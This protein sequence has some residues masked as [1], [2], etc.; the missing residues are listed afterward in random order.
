M[1]TRGTLSPEEFDKIETSLPQF[2][3]PK[4]R[5]RTPVKEQVEAEGEPSVEPVVQSSTEKPVVEQQPDVPQVAQQAP[6]EEEEKEQP[7]PFAEVEG[8]PSPGDTGAE[9][10][11]E[12]EDSMLFGNSMI[13]ESHIREFFDAPET[14][15][16]TFTED[17]QDNRRLWR[18]GGLGGEVAAVLS[19]IHDRWIEGTDVGRQLQDKTELALYPLAD[20]YVG[21]ASAVMRM[22][23][24]V[25]DMIPSLNAKEM[26]NGL[27]EMSQAW[28]A[29]RAQD[30]QNLF[31]EGK[32]AEAF[33]RSISGALGDV[34]GNMKLFLSVGKVVRGGS[35]GVVTKDATWK[36]VAS[37]QFGRATFGFWYAFTNTK[38]TLEERAKAGALSFAYMSTPVVSSLART[39][40]GA[41]AADFLLNSGIDSVWSPESGFDFPIKWVDGKPQ[42]QGQFEDARK[43]AAEEAA[44]LGQPELEEQLFYSKIIPIVGASFG[45]ALL[46]T[47]ARA[48]N[49]EIQRAMADGRPD[50]SK[51]SP[52]VQRYYSDLDASM[53]SMGM[54]DALI[55][56]LNSSAMNAVLDGKISADAMIATHNAS[57]R[58]F[59][60]M[61]DAHTERMRPDGMIEGGRIMPEA[62]QREVSLEREVSEAATRVPDADTVSRV[63]GVMQNKDEATMALSIF[64]QNPASWPKLQSL[65]WEKVREGEILRDPIGPTVEAARDLGAQPAPP[66]GRQPPVIP[67]LTRATAAQAEAERR[68]VQ[69]LRQQ[70]KSLSGSVDK[71]WEA[72]EK[73]PQG[74]KI[75]QLR[76]EYEV[77]ESEG[78]TPRQL[79]VAR[80]KWT[81]AQ[82]RGVQSKEYQTWIDASKRWRDAEQSAKQAEVNQPEKPRYKAPTKEQ[83]VSDLAET[84]KPNPE[85]WTPERIATIETVLPETARIQVIQDFASERPSMGKLS[86][87]LDYVQTMVQ[88]TKSLGYGKIKQDGSMKQTKGNKMARGVSIGL[89]RLK[90]DPEFNGFNLEARLDS[91]VRDTKEFG[92]SSRE[93]IIAS[94][95][96]DSPEE[97]VKLLNVMRLGRGSQPLMDTAL[98][99]AGGAIRAPEYRLPEEERNRIA[100]ALPDGLNPTVVQRFL[101][102]VSEPPPRNPDTFQSWVRA[103]SAFLKQAHS[104]ERMRDPRDLDRTASRWS[105]RA[106]NIQS[107]RYFFENI[108]SD[109][110]DMQVARLPQKFDLEVRR[111]GHIADVTTKA[112][113]E[114]ENGRPN[115]RLVRWISSHAD[116]EGSIVAKLGIDP[117]SA[118]GDDLAVLERANK[119]L[120][121]LS[122]SDPKRHKQVIK[123]M[124][125]ISTQLN[126]GTAMNNRYLQFHEFR[127]EW[128]KK[129]DGMSKAERWAEAMMRGDDD[130]VKEIETQMS[131]VIPMRYNPETK[132]GER[133]PL[134]MMNRYLNTY[135]VEGKSLLMAELFEADWGTRQYYYPSERPP[136]IKGGY[137]DEG[138]F[139]SDGVNAGR[140]QAGAVTSTIKT[141]D[142]RVDMKSGSLFAT[143]YRHIYNLEVQSRTV[144]LKEQLE[145]KLTQAAKDQYIGKD[146]QGLVSRW[147][148]NQWGQG[149]PAERVA[150]W[151]SKMNSMFWTTYPLAVSRIAWYSAR[152]MLYQGVPWGV[153]TTQFKIGDITTALPRV[154]N[155]LRDS[156][157]F[158]RRWFENQ[159]TSDISQKQIIFNEQV[160]MKDPASLHDTSGKVYRSRIIDEGLTLAKDW[161]SW[162]I[163]ASDSFNRMSI[164]TASHVIAEKYVDQWIRGE[165]NYDRIENALMLKTVTPSQRSELAQLFD[166]GIQT[167]TKQG[168][169]D[170]MARIAEIKNE[171]ANF[172]YRLGGKSMLEQEPSTR[173]FTGLITYPRGTVELF[174][175]Q[176]WK[177]FYRAMTNIGTKDFDASELVQGLKVMGMQQIGM[178]MSGVVFDQLIGRKRGLQEVPT[179]HF[180]TSSL[181][182]GPMNVGASWMIDAW[183]NFA[184]LGSQMHT[185]GHTQ[186][187]SEQ[188]GEIQ[189]LAFFMIPMAADVR[190][191][192]ESAHN[193]VYADNVEALMAII[194]KDVRN[195]RETERT[196]YEQWVKHPVFGGAST[197]ADEKKELID[198]MIDQSLL[199]KMWEAASK[200]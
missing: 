17:W 95:R 72:Y 119:V 52:E 86:A 166:M 158:T 24:G 147:M 193:R 46:T 150:I 133:V 188:S 50:L 75:D 85:P 83:I 102:S 12:E 38:G 159:Y 136:V 127:K 20:M 141:R 76:R 139:M 182:P 110:G 80:S 167:G 107:S 61:K 198:W 101:D 16:T 123:L 137:V 19:T 126:G 45:F 156:N 152:N 176:G 108:A 51:A 99:A 73:S 194:G 22:G 67:E 170:W 197:T 58:I 100:T 55:Q 135:N 21:A 130:A 49:N 98:A 173:M 28:G 70:A 153:M 162:S 121:G 190:N 10:S 89:S 81:R 103:Q 138:S 32:S 14:P 43:M 54:P 92:P 84:W 142:G 1:P 115:M 23:S 118:S 160:L 48:N 68:S 200:Y 33:Y 124:E 125:N 120:D 169:V 7:P 44:A 82:E 29:Q 183:G 155:A 97:A 187:L 66:D 91:Y 71:A 171:N 36:A 181:G 178:I 53:K 199:L 151:A 4:T 192:A 131:R 2:E 163:G 62:P 9:P 64:S 87:N 180:L 185:Q 132:E 26:A 34:Y 161:A 134:E 56:R 40:V 39:N 105:D 168:F 145:S 63:L 8:L 143:L 157:S 35:G 25:F 184:E 111:A 186:I 122:K 191:L 149:A 31:A 128:E 104:R 15:P 94:W 60:R 189:K 90:D 78:A 114:G 41:V 174:Y 172:L 13:D 47:S 148:Q 117:R 116:L 177:P 88:K 3:P 5:K 18:G 165:K 109:M 6:V 37:N 144:E 42:L 69:A 146:V 27:E 106:R 30:I 57:T 96:A 164:G 59:G 140:V 179:Y 112:L 65:W 175:Q 195:Y 113:T 154:V 77:L 196:Y 129:T 11:F 93:A 79:E 74:Q